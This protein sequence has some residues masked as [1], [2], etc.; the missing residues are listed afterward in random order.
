M[1]ATNLATKVSPAS[2]RRCI[3]Q[4]AR[5]TQQSL[6]D[7]AHICSFSSCYL[8]HQSLN[9]Q[10]LQHCWPVHV[11]CTCTCTTQASHADAVQKS[12]YGQ[13]T[14]RAK[15]TNSTPRH[16]RHPVMLTKPLCRAPL[17]C[18]LHQNSRSNRRSCCSSA[19]KAYACSVS[20]AVHVL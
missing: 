18:A 9:L 4:H 16:C 6:Y 8:R 12:L 5:A 15:R 14:D 19:R 2:S 17:N 10:Q 20:L 1:H 3:Q 11:Q 13:H 7:T